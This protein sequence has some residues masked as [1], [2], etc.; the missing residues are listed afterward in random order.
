MLRKVRSL[1]LLWIFGPVLGFAYET[2]LALR[3]T[4][5]RVRAAVGGRSLIVKSYGEVNPQLIAIIAS[6]ASGG[7]PKSVENL[8]QL[9]AARN[10]AILLV[11]NGRLNEQSRARLGPMLWRSIERPNYGRDFGA[12]Q[13]GVLHLLRERI[14]AKRLIVANDSMFYDMARA[15]AML[16][17]LI[18]SERHFTAA[19][20]NHEPA[21]H[22]GSFLFAVSD[23]V[24]TS[25][26]WRKYWRAYK[27]SSSRLHAIRAGELGLSRALI[28]K[29]GYVPEVLYS[30]TDIAPWMRSWTAPDLALR[31]TRL[32]T[33]LRDDVRNAELHSA[34]STPPMLSSELVRFAVDFD[35]SDAIDRLEGRTARALKN[36]PIGGVVDAL[37]KKMEHRSQ[38]HWAGALM[39]ERLNLGFM[40]KDFAYRGVYDINDFIQVMAELNY[41][42][43][44]EVQLE[45][46]KRGSPASLRGIQR[47][48]YQAGHI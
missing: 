38:I 1:L 27:P 16:E 19:T 33:E 10:A 12:Y 18:T 44:A 11:C 32:P 25:H 17:R 37:L 40:K 34:I 26:V 9:L 20:E 42:D 7:V 22:V 46:R 39:V 14:T 13:A 3:D 43:M 35:P 29:G 24:Q 48:L 36:I 4:W 6:Q 23:D 31:L 2:Y 30:V 41:A 15:P 45:T 5:T 21:Y 28:K 47:I 8:I